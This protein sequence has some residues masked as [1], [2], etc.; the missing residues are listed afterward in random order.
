MTML[1]LFQ[2]SGSDGTVVYGGEP[3]GMFETGNGFTLY[4]AATQRFSR[5]GAA[6]ELY[7]PDWRCFRSAISLRGP[8]QAAIAIRLLE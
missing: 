1:P 4:A 7:Q 2:F 3:A 8:A 5:Y 6:Q